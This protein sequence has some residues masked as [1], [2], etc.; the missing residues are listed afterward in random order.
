MQGPPTTCIESSKEEEKDE[1]PSVIDSGVVCS[2]RGAARAEN[3]QETSTQ[4]HSCISP[5][6]LVYED[7]KEEED[8]LPSVSGP[9]I[10]SR[11]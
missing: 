1:L 7:D 8:D 6:I 3:A 10:D 5:R 4:S 2:G 11:R 9:S